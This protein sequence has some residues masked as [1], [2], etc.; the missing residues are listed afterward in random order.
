MRHIDADA[1]TQDLIKRG[2][3]PAIVKRA[4]EDAPSIDFEKTAKSYA[5]RNC[6][7]CKHKDLDSESENYYIC[8][9]CFRCYGYTDNFEERGE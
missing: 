3:Y 2:F 7:R 6:H 1:L 9:Y 5:E 4:I 8:E